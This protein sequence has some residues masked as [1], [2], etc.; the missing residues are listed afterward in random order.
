M[1]RQSLFHACVRTPAEGRLTVWGPRGPTMAQRGPGFEGGQE[2][3]SMA[4]PGSIPECPW[5]RQAEPLHTLQDRG[6]RVVLAYSHH[7]H[8]WG[9]WGALFW[10][11]WTGSK[12]E[13]SQ[14][15]GMRPD[16]SAQ[17]DLVEQATWENSWPEG[18]EEGA[19]AV[20][21]RCQTQAEGEAGGQQPL[22]QAP[23][24]TAPRH[25]L[26]CPSHQASPEHEHGPPVLESRYSRKDGARPPA[27]SEPSP[28]CPQTVTQES[29]GHTPAAVAGHSPS[30]GDGT[31]ALG[32]EQS[33]SHTDQSTMESQT[34][35]E[36]QKGPATGPT[37]GGLGP[38]RC[39][40]RV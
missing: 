29:R 32:A 19:S 14:H 37:E 11:L 2:L 4:A 7:H 9:A 13:A 12:P 15:G 8:S 5:C 3:W 40:G 38:A 30:A 10:G 23:Q 34:V 27:E 33:H 36:P 39:F 35:S 31:L 20:G 1:G 21:T 26:A 24:S 16:K 6:R 25:P 17:D 28:S 22:H 18:N